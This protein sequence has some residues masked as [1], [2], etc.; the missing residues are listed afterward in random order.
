MSKSDIEKIKGMSKAANSDH[1]P[2]NSAS[3]PELWMWKKTVLKQL[4]KLLPKTEELSQAI[5]SDNEDTDFTLAKKEAMKNTLNRPSEL[6]VTSLIPGATPAVEET[7][8][9]TEV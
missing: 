2:W 9:S 4:A 5:A 6:D 8:T 1:S 7:V 3:D